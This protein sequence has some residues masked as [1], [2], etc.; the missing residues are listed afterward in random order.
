M[1]L[2]VFVRATRNRRRRRRRTLLLRPAIGADQELPRRRRLAGEDSLRVRQGLEGGAEEELVESGVEEV[3]RFVVEPP[4]PV[5][6][7]I[8]DVISGI[9]ILHL[10]HAQTAES[11]RGVQRGVS[12]T[13]HYV[14]SHENCMMCMPLTSYVFCACNLRPLCE[15]LHRLI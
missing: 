11:E 2:V 14:A 1:R 10:H 6:H 3:A 9:T 8:T 7:L 13:E 5:L 15:E 12:S 4:R